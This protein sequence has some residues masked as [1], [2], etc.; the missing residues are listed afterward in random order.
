MS[1]LRIQHVLVAFWLASGCLLSGCGRP[2]QLGS[3]EA[4][5]GEVDAL[6]T[7]VT[8]RRADL[9]EQSCGRL[10][11]LHRSGKVP[12]AAWQQLTAICDLA[13]RQQWQPAA[14]QLWKFMRGQR[15]ERSST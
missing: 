2:A 9:L 15:K 12:A 5:F 13:D 8:S 14:E 6:Y 3:D 10:T 1:A 7:A 4:V 11:E